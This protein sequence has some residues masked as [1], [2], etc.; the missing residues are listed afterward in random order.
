[1]IEVDRYQKLAAQRETAHASWQKE[2]TE[3]ME[4]HRKKVEKLQEEFQETQTKEKHAIERIKEEKTLAERVHAETMDQ[5]EKDTDQEIE[6]LKDD[7]ETQLKK[8]N[9]KK[10]EL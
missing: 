7:K 8:E 2:F 3:M 6:E 4:D 5:L 1:M 10:V 9:A